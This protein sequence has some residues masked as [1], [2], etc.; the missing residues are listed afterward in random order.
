MSIS[1]IQNC[2]KMKRGIYDPF[3]HKKLLK[4]CINLVSVPEE[5]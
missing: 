1:L 4:N 2:Y 3:G 5:P